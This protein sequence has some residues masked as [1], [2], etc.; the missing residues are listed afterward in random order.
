LIDDAGKSFLF[1]VSGNG[2][3]GGY[4]ADTADGVSPLVFEV[5]DDSTF[6]QVISTFVNGID[7]TT[8]LGGTFAPSNSAADE[9]LDEGLMTGYI[10]NASGGLQQEHEIEFRAAS[11]RGELEITVEIY[12]LTQSV[13]V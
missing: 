12:A 8:A 9:L 3:V 13:Q 11:G 4:F 7:R 2:D 5:N 10:R 6:P 1:E